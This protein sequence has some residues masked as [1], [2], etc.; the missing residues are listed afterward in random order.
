MY[1]LNTATLE[2]H[3]FD[4]GTKVPPY[5]ILSH[6]WGPDEQTFRE[7]PLVKDSHGRRGVLQRAS[8]RAFR[9]PSKKV[10]HACAR[11]LTD[12]YRWLWT[13]TTCIDA[14]NSAELSE[15]IN[16]FFELYAHAAMCYAYLADVPPRADAHAPRSAFRASRW[17]RRVWTL[18]ELIAPAS[19]IFLAADWTPL[20][21]KWRLAPLIEAITGIDRL[22]LTHKRPLEQVSVACRMSWAARRESRREEDRAYSLMGI[23]GVCMPTIYGER[24]RS[25]FIRLQEEIIK[26][27]DDQSIFAWGAALHDYGAGTFVSHVR[28]HDYEP[29]ADLE[30]LFASSPS[31]FTDCADVSPIPLAE[32]A[33]R[34][35][36]VKENV[37]VYTATAAGVRTTLPVVPV[38]QTSTAFDAAM[39]GLLSCVDGHGR[40]VAL[41]LRTHPRTSHKLFVG[42]YVSRGSRVNTYCRTTRLAAHEHH[43]LLLSRL[44]EVIIHSFG[45]TFA[46]ASS[47]SA[48]SYAAS[49]SS[50]PSSAGSSSAASS[51]RH[52]LIFFEPPCTVRI[53]PAARKALAR[54]GFLAP[55]LPARGF[56]LACAGEARAISF[57][58]Y[59]SFTVHFGVCAVEQGAGATQRAQLWAAATFDGGSDL[60]SLLVSQSGCGDCEDGHGGH[61]GHDGEDGERTLAERGADVCPDESMLVQYWKDHRRAF[62]N[63]SREVR[64]AFHYPCRLSSSDSVSERGIAEVYE[65]DIT[66]RGYYHK[67]ERRRYKSSAKSYTIGSV[68]ASRV[69]GH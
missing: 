38:G 51:A 57:I 39:L 44:Q 1:L 31:D 36:L 32:F 18:Q 62:G 11:A 67:A 7:T 47:Y 22:V 27:S 42:G 69:K 53:A 61:G 2:L 6:V 33:Q 64:L 45:F 20:G 15:A 54:M 46:R 65:L 66:F 29:Q 9:R 43:L 16:S 34:L 24:G 52:S 5:A 41:F 37:P 63:G 23:F 8:D 60:D 49:S 40:L 55:V 3:R 68:S 48:S 30:T 26:R 56:R 13:D 59:E 50:S 10:R 19:V 25:A 12:G 17:F 58:G 35:D 14:A 28:D 4:K 21:A